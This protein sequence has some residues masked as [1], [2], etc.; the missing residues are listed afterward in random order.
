M[1]EAD[2]G[3][4]SRGTSRLP[5]SARGQ[6]AKEESSFEPCRGRVVFEQRLTSLNRNK[7]TCC[8]Q[9]AEVGRGKVNKQTLVLDGSKEIMSTAGDLKLQQCY[10]VMEQKQQEKERRELKL[11]LLRA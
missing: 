4:I 5:A 8:G 6:R 11:A 10:L 3:A 7:H 9:R 1:M 2:S